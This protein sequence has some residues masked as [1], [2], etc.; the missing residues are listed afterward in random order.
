MR[1]QNTPSCGPELF[2]PGD[3]Q[4]Y[5]LLVSLREK[6]S[7]IIS[8]STPIGEPVCNGMVVNVPIFDS[9]LYRLMPLPIYD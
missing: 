8:S 1:N 9:F 5:I 6:I 4:S 7:P 2:S 3:V